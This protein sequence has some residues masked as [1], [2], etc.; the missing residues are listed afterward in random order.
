MKRFTLLTIALFGILLTAQA[1]P[2]FKRRAKARAQEKTQVQ[3]PA[4]EEA[5]TP[6]TPQTEVQN[7]TKP[8]ETAQPQAAVADTTK[9]Q[10][11]APAPA[12][13]D[14]LT[15]AKPKEVAKIQERPLH[16]PQ[17]Q[18]CDSLKKRPVKP[19]KPMNEA[20]IIDTLITADKNLSVILFNDNTWRY[21][22]TG[23]V[24]ADETVFSKYWSED[25][26]FPYY[27]VPLSS[28]PE[29]TPIQLVDSL[30]AYHY[31]YKGY[32]TS[33][34]GPRNGRRHAGIDIALKTGDTIRA[35]FNGK[36]RYSKYHANGY[37]ELVIIRHDNGIETFHA[38]LSKRLVEAGERVVAGQTIGLGGST[39]RSSGPHLHFECRYMGQAFDPERII[40]FNTGELR[41]DFIL[42]KRTYF[43]A[44]SRFEQDWNSERVPAPAPATPTVVAK[45]KPKPKPAP[46]PV[47]YTIENGDCLGVIAAKYN[48]TVEKLCNLNKIEDP[49]K[50]RIGQKI[51]VK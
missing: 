25:Y 16:K 24:K 40:N 50:I 29:T 30:R 46:K 23:N 32:I 27:N 34:Y 19:V 12:K 38:H 42:L 35:T 41:R 10:A 45:P 37:G 51:R 18:V 1:E 31:P 2:R 17:V 14:T 22:Q 28:I 21:V 33:R 8:Q 4:T 6:A 47:Y 9:V 7:A 15:S 13:V 20:G 26:L 44:S 49:D 3:A 48:T 5:K 36:V 39:G 11:P 43:D